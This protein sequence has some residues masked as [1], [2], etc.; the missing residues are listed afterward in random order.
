MNRSRGIFAASLLTALA[1]TLSA[2][3]EYNG[4][5][6][7]PTGSQCASNIAQI[8]VGDG[9][10]E[11][12]CGCTGQPPATTVLPAPAN[13]TCHVPLN[14]T[15]VFQ[16]IGIQTQHQIVNSSGLSFP[17]GPVITPGPGNV[18]TSTA[19]FIQT[20]TYGFQDDYDL[21]L[22]GSIIVP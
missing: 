7:D 10:L 19:T 20:G 15:I 6:I 4:P 11:F 14:T 17:S 18:T 1:A 16:Y 13:L 5:V 9:F 8:G 2:C 21:A 22:Q 3:Q 12:L